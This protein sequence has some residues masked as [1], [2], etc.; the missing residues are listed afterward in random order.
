MTDDSMTAPSLY[1]ATMT[2]TGI[3]KRDAA[4]VS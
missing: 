1:A 4:S 2:L 3:V